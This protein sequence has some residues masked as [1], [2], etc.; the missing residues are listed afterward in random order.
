MKP[1]PITFPKDLIQ[2]SSADAAA[3]QPEGKV[4]GGVFHNCPPFQDAAHT[5]CISAGKLDR[6][7]PLGS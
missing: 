1:F 5:S 2:L 4:P 3:I 6:V 7:G